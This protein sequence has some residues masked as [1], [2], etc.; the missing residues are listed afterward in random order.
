M[1]EERQVNWY[2]AYYPDLSRYQNNDKRST[3][4]IFTNVYNIGWLSRD[5]IFPLGE[6]SQVW[7]DKLVSLILTR[8]IGFIYVERGIDKCSFCKESV[9]IPLSDGR[10]ISLGI[11]E[12]WIPSSLTD[13]VF[14]APDLIYHYIAEH[15]YKPP[16]EYL[17][18]VEMFDIA[19]G[20][21]ADEFI[22]QQIEKYEQS[23]L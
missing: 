14:A 17:N 16:D 5:H 10:S 23:E 3:D 7:L 20:W 22:K 12:V 13:K 6:V 1:D 19:S 8:G 15:R 21:N 4:K 18:A 2:Q 9:D 11:S